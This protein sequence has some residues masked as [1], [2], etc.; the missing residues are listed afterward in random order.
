MLLNIQQYLDKYHYATELEKLVLL[1]PYENWNWSQLSKNPNISLHFLYNFSNKIDYT[2]INYNKNLTENFIID[3]YHQI[4]WKIILLENTNLSDKFI[5][6]CLYSYK[7]GNIENISLPSTFSNEIYNNF[8]NYYNNF[9]NKNF[10]KKLLIAFKL[11]RNLRLYYKYY[12]DKDNYISFIN[13][14]NKEQLKKYQNTLNWNIISKYYNLSNDFIIYSYFKI[15][16]KLISSNS[17]INYLIIRNNNNLIDFNIL[18]TVFP[19]VQSP[20]FCSLMGI[21]L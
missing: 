20:L 3:N 15:N 5:L 7:L 12:I 18:S 13:K 6:N 14:L 11:F 10:S 1:Y 9:N 16:W 2:M 4:N 17:S 21:R 19:K 8:K